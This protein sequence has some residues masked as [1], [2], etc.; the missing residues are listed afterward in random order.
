MCFSACV[1]HE[2]KELS[3]TGP[4][5]WSIRNTTAKR[6]LKHNI[7]KLMG[8]RDGRGRDCQA[9]CRKMSHGDIS[10]S[11]WTEQWALWQAGSYM[12]VV[13]LVYGAVS[14]AFQRPGL[15]FEWEDVWVGGWHG[16]G[17]QQSSSPTGRGA[18]RTTKGEEAHCVP[19]E[20]EDGA[21]GR[22]LAGD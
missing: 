21:Q 17:A 3:C 11:K 2:P 12:A 7:P 10:C 8:S 4:L 22:Q 20:M 15:M 16:R 18:C 6:I 14:K 13:S 5:P 19:N 1:L 9:A